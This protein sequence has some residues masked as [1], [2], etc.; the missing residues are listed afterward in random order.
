MV[1]RFLIFCT[2]FLI[3]IHKNLKINTE[4]ILY[5]KPLKYFMQKV[6]LYILISWIIIACH[7]DKSRPTGTT[8]SLDSLTGNANDSEGVIDSM[9]VANA[10]KWIYDQRTNPNKGEIDRLAFV[11]SGQKLFF[12]KHYKG[13]STLSLN[14]RR[15]DGRTEAYLMIHKGEFNLDDQ[16]VRIL[17]GS[18]KLLEFRMRR[19]GE[20]NHMVY[21]EQS[22]AVINELQKSTV[23]EV[24]APFHLEG[25]MKCIFHTNQFSWEK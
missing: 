16:P 13:G 3:L 1:N 5:S 17:F 20:G 7:S 18:G 8:E 2:L 11:V 12:K 19:S 15:M 10:G 22:E 6:F 14:V 21:L 4:C 24:D 25:R 9:E 23:F